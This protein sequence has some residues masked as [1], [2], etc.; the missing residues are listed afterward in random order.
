[1]EMISGLS[2]I[3]PT[4]TCYALYF[5]QVWATRGYPQLPSNG[6]IDG[7]MLYV[8]LAHGYGQLVLG[9][10]CAIMHQSHVKS[11]DGSVSSDSRDCG[12]DATSARLEIFAP[13]SAKQGLERP[14]LGGEFPSTPGLAG[15]ALGV[16]LPARPSCSRP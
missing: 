10:R 8:L 7:V 13:A 12:V 6:W 15:L 9:G 1:M 16:L 11:Y 2:R 5:R 4:P 3:K 14:R